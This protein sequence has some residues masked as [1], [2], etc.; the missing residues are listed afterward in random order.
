[1]ASRAE[2]AEQIDTMLRVLGD[3]A[4]FLPEMA[5]CWNE[6]SE[7]SR[8]VFYLEWRNLMGGLETLNADYYAGRMTA[9]QGYR[10]QD[11]LRKLKDLLPV[12]ERL[13]LNAPSIP[14]EA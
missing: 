1:M 7:V 10:Y 8:D 2:L 12:I 14:L 11:V 13:E 9:E 3:E 6:T 5:A 4:D